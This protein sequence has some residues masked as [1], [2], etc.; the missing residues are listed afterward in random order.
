[1]LVSP[2]YAATS[3]NSKAAG[4]PKVLTEENFG[5]W[6]YGVYIDDYKLGNI[7][8][9]LSQN[10]DAVIAEFLL[11]MRIPSSLAKEEVE[12]AKYAFTQTITRH[13]FNKK[14]GL[15]SHLSKTYG[16][17]LYVDYNSLLENKYFEE[18][19]WTL[20]AN[21]K[22]DFVYEVLETANNKI[23]ERTYKLPSLSM[24]DYFAGINFVHLNPKV[25]DV[26]KIEVNDLDFNNGVYWG[27][28][29]TLKK[30]FKLDNMNDT[31]HYL[32]KLEL[33][34]GDI[35]MLKVDQYGNVIEGDLYGLRVVREPKDQ[36]LTL[37]PK[38]I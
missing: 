6:F 13:K 14:T 28:I 30:R 35:S 34:N 23:K 31:Y 37:D 25:G 22:G 24:A 26:K 29:L 12:G 20:T 5:E 1:M 10:D 11:N 17:K 19:M 15:L 3:D 32:V 16:E 2:P 9:K 18:K 21:Y 36:A 33:D 27:L 7:I 38:N 8:N 4:E